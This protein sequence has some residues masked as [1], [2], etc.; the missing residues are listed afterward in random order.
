MSQH[1]QPPRTV[2]RRPVRLA[3]P[4]LGLALLLSGCT[5]VAA[6]AQDDATGAADQ[7]TAAAEPSPEPAAFPLTID[8]CGVPVTVDAAP[9]R[10]VTIKSSATEMLLALGVGD[11]IVG[12]GFPDGPVPEEYADAAADLPLLSDR[13][14]AA[15]VVLQA[16][17]DLVY[18]GWESNLTAEGA[19][20]RAT[21]AG[22]G[23][24]TYVAPSA[25]KDPAYQPDHL[26]FDEV[27]DEIG[28]VAALLGVPEAATEL[29]AEQQA[30]LD[31]LAPDDSGRTALWYS[32]GTDVPYVGAGI[33]APQMIMSAVGLTNIAE[34]VADT[35]ASFSWE[36][37]AQDDPDVIVLVDAAWNTAEQKK[38]LLATNPATANLTAVR[39]ERY[40]VVP[41]AA[42]EAGVRNVPAALDLAE[43]LAA[44]DVT[45]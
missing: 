36:Q 30:A 35:W 19:G 27:F 2:R 23:V 5:A 45:G 4:G 44:L 37:V 7:A 38:E 28:E 25:C 1:R 6:P 33:G 9:Q 42:S 41:F 16:E 21:L 31:A 13:V 17:P 43:Q 12:T 10:V 34:G 39:A 8:N 14:P 22:L 20:D 3:V 40:L 15:E 32:S 18:A 24:A 26:T 29:V 11:R